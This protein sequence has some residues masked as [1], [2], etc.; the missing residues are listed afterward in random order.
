MNFL[1]SSC[2][3]FNPQNGGNIVYNTL[4]SGNTQIDRCFALGYRL[5]ILA[6]SDVSALAALDLR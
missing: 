3:R 6:A 4:S 1:G 5:G 2:N